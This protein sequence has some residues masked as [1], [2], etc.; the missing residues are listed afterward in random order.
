MRNAVAQHDLH[1]DRSTLFVFSPTPHDQSYQMQMEQFDE[2]LGALLG[3]EVVIAEVFE[4][5]RGRIGSEDLTIEGS[6]GLRR[7]FRIPSGRF[8]VM[9]VGKDS[10]IK[11]VADSCVS[12]EEIVMRVENEPKHVEMSLD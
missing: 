6:D 10:H 7:Q 5:G 9:L 11:M 2:R 1:T 3:H 8:R 4:D 12:F